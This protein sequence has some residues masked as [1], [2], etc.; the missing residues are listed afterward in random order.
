[1]YNTTKGVSEGTRR[2]PKGRGLERFS[3]KFLVALFAPAPPLRPRAYSSF[4]PGVDGH[5]LRLHERGGDGHREREL[6][7]E[8]VRRRALLPVVGPARA[9]AADPGA[10]RH[11]PRRLAGP[12]AYRGN[13]NAS[14][15]ASAT[16]PPSGG[17]AVFCSD[18]FV[19]RFSRFSRFDRSRSS[20][21][22]LARTLAALRGAAANLSAA[23]RAG[24]GARPARRPAGRSETA[25]RRNTGSGSSARSGTDPGAVEGGEG[26]PTGT[27][28]TRS[29]SATARRGGPRAGGTAHSCVGRR[30]G[31]PGRSRGPPGGSGGSRGSGPPTPR[32]PRRGAPTSTPPP[33]ARRTRRRTRSRPARGASDDGGAAPPPLPDGFRVPDAAGRVENPPRDRDEPPSGV[34]EPR[35]TRP[36]PSSSSSRAS[37]SSSSYSSSSSDWAWTPSSPPPPAGVVADVE[38]S[39]VDP[40]HHRD[41]HRLGR[42]LAGGGPSAARLRAAPARAPGEH[43]LRGAE[44]EQDAALVEELRVPQHHPLGVLPEPPEER[45]CERPG[46]RPARAR[47]RVRVERRPLGSPLPASSNASPSSLARLRPPRA[48][49]TLA[50][51]RSASR[52]SLRLASSN[53]RVMIFCRIPASQGSPGPPIRGDR[54]AV[55]ARGPHRPRRREAWR[56]RLVRAWPTTNSP[57][58]RPPPPR[59][60]PLLATAAPPRRATR[61]PLGPPRTTAQRRPGRTPRPRASARGR[62]EPNSPTP[63]PTPRPTPPSRRRS[64]RRLIRRRLR[65]RLYDAF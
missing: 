27:N 60:P 38:H 52:A 16:P 53:T 7:V 47:A 17:P 63:T 42:A 46:P 28:A 35:A 49:A 26:A 64:R 39:A 62:S 22:S 20:L 34:R 12:R 6:R 59:P 4:P 18:S 24:A 55:E 50:L 65:L 43:V 58:L 15:S 54:S 56:R 9:A 40:V 33:W 31:P 48:F 23:S 14:A 21:S 1:M 51:P 32:A 10:A 3:S 5:D 13:G 45:A 57:P 8:H 30:A 44:P 29:M 41:Q 25:A 61:A 36:S 37:Y 2:R 19:S 11:E